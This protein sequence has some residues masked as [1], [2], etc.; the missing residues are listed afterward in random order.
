MANDV[1]NILKTKGINA[2]IRIGNVDKDNAKLFES[3][4]AWVLA[5][6]SADN[7]LPLE[8][9]GGY[10]VSVKDNPCYYRGWNFYTPNNLKNIFNF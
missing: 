6:V 1:W 7:W 9:T 3:N 5:E 2:K 4:H 8:T 10:L